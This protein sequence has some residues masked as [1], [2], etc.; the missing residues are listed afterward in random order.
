MASLAA[1]RAELSRCVYLAKSKAAGFGS[2]LLLEISL[3]ILVKNFHRF[4]E[5]KSLAI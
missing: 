2:L 3:T 5:S 4:W 1:L